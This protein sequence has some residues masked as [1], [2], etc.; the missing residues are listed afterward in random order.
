MITPNTFDILNLT[1]AG[2]GKTP[3]DV[4]QDLAL[5]TEDKRALLASWA[6]DARAVQD[7]PGLR[8]LDDGRV[9]QIDD[10]LDALKALDSFRSA[11]PHADENA[12][13][14]IRRGHW[15]RLGR[16]WR[17]GSH[18]DDDDNPPTAPA[19]VRPFRPI[20]GGDLAAVA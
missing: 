19:A 7:H 6:S 17:K 11:N 1:Q 13:P 3:M 2:G 5:T 12:L 18:D 15:S 8:R 4:V 9:V 20:T 16:I 10:V 14:F